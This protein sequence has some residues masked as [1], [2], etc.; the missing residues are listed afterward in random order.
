MDEFGIPREPNAEERAVLAEEEAARKKEESMSAWEWLQ[1]DGD[2][3]ARDKKRA[4]G[5][6][7]AGSTAHKAAH[8]RKLTKAEKKRMLEQKVAGRGHDWVDVMGHLR[9]TGRKA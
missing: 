1:A 2:L 8:K 3:V 4:Q 5:Q 6:A 7:A 9:R